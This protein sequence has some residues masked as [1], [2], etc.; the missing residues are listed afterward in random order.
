MLPELSRVLKSAARLKVLG[1]YS[2]FAESENMA[3]DY[4]QHQHQRFESGLSALRTLPALASAQAHLANSAALLRSPGFHYDFARVGYALWAPLDF[5]PPESA[6]ALNSKLRPVMRLVCPVSHVK[7]LSEGDTVG[8]SRTYRGQAG[9][10]I[11]TLPI[12]YGDGYPRALSNRGHVGIH[13]KLAP[14]VGNVSMDQTT[15]SLGVTP[16]IPARVGDGVVLL[17]DPPR[18]PGLAEVAH[19]AGT[20]GYQIMTGLNHRIPRVYLYEGKEFPAP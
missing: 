14:V 5:D 2:H 12:G 10:C 7:I 18:E 15:I 3:S 16:G 13:G 8:Y 17:G 1:I 20:I 6:P 4:A 19:A 9:E 11:A